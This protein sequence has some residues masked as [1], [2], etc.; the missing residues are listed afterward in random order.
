MIKK[1]TQKD[2]YVYAHWENLK[3]PELMGIVKSTPFRG[4]EIFSFEYDDA[5]LQ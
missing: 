4:K 5:W 1:Q 3:G 2:I